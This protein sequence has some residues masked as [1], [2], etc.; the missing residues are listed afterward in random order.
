MCTLAI[1]GQAIADSPRQIDVPAAELTLALQ[2]LVQQTGV[3]F[4]YS[5]EE[6]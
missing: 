2:Q 6:I 3:E 5:A 4:V 1:A